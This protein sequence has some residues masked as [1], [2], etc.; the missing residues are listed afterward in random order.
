MVF[1]IFIEMS[2]KGS[3]YIKVQYISPKIEDIKK[4]IEQ[5]FS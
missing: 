5:K 2:K 1:K 3:F 4:I